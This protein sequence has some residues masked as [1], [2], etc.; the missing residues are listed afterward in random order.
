MRET[1]WNKQVVF[2]YILSASCIPF[3]HP[4]R[5]T[6]GM[7][8]YIGWMDPKSGKLSRN[9]NVSWLLRDVRIERL[10]RCKMPAVANINSKRLRCGQM[11]HQVRNPKSAFRGGGVTVTREQIFDLIVSQAREVAPELQEHIFQDRDQL[12]ELGINSVD[13]AEILMLVIETLSLS[14][15]RVELFG[16]KSIGE[17]ADLV[18][19]KLGQVADIRGQ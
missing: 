3:K 7:V 8:L 15:P 16:P 13:R 9:P 11:R 4:R 5:P 17:L 1:D 2:S 6:G 12:H 19:H 18:H 10:C 14:I